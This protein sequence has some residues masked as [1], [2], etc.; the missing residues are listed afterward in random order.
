[1]G[2]LR[3]Q[4]RYL[5]VGEMPLTFLVP[6]KTDQQSILHTTITTHSD[7]AV[8]RSCYQRFQ[9][10]LE[11][12]DRQNST[13]L[14]ELVENYLLDFDLTA[15]RAMGDHPNRY[16]LFQLRY[17]KG[18][19]RQDCCK[20]LGLEVFSYT[21]EIMQIERAVGRALAQRGLFPLNSYFHSAKLQLQPL[22]A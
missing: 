10:C 20:I 5:L 22:A 12:R 7:A 18:A 6:P 1:M 2:S 11:Y 13:S 15:K 21:S 14:G 9:E 4:R 8:F 17:L 16:R 19:N 3:R